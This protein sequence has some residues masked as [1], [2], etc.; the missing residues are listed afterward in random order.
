MVQCTPCLAPWGG[1]PYQRAYSLCQ[2]GFLGC[3][4]RR[5]R[6]QSRSCTPTTLTPSVAACWFS[7]AIYIKH[8]APAGKTARPARSGGTQAKNTRDFVASPSHRPRS[9]TLQRICL[10]RNAT[11]WGV[12]HL[13]FRGLKN[14]Q[15]LETVARPFLSFSPPSF[16][17]SLIFKGKK[18][19][20]R[21]GW[22]KWPCGGLGRNRGILRQNRGTPFFINQWVR[23]RTTRC[24]GFCQFA[25]I[26]MEDQSASQRRM[27]AREAIGHSAPALMGLLVG[28]LSNRPTPYLRSVTL[29]RCRSACGR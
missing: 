25:C 26:P 5:S 2:S 17:F 16:S 19:R 27:V 9:L 13:Q 23:R 7:A 15:S 3:G 4:S 18:E 21:D 20:S 22:Q 1:L 24:H 6:Y 14:R 8:N 29:G 28:A 10:P 12:A 11:K